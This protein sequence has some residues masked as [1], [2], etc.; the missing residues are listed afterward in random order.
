MPAGVYEATGIDGEGEFR[1]VVGPVPGEDGAAA[2]AAFPAAEHDSAA[3]DQIAW[4]LEHHTEHE[5]LTEVLHRVNE[6]VSATGRTGALPSD[7]GGVE[8][9]S[10]LERGVL[11]GDILA[12]REQQ[13]DS[14]REGPQRSAPGRGIGRDL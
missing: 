6:H 11:L 4:I 5:P 1:L 13:L 2:S 8:P 3:M 7:L 10:R 12:E 9:S 14:D